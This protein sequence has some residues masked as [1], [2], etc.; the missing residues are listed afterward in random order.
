MLADAMHWET[1]CEQT[2]LNCETDVWAK[3]LTSRA[4]YLRTTRAFQSAKLS[5][6]LMACRRNFDHKFQISFL[7][8]PVTRLE[9]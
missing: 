9:F 2:G 7:G 1:I 5:R 8:V 6:A 4:F 3:L